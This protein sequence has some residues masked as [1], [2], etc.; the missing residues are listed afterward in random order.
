MK[1]RRS[2]SPDV[3]EPIAGFQSRS[4]SIWTMNPHLVIFLSM[5]TIVFSA[6]NTDAYMFAHLAHQV[7]QGANVHPFLYAPST[8]T[9]RS[10]RF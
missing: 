3:G 2:D 7:Y 5:P 6:I 1:S 10:V 8:E 9:N 4:F